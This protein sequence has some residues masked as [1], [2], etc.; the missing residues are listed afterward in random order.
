MVAIS[1]ITEND[2][3]IIPFMLKWSINFGIKF[4]K[5]NCIGSGN[6]FLIAAF[7]ES[8]SIFL[9]LKH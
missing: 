9:L 5:C 6:F 8:I 2:F 4:T 3:T 1:G 7:R